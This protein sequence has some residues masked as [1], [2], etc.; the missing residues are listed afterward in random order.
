MRGSRSYLKLDVDA[1]EAVSGSAPIRSFL[2]APMLLPRVCPT[3][4]LDLDSAK[5]FLIG[6][7]PF[8]ATPFGA[9]TYQSR[10]VWVA[11]PGLFQFR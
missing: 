4:V 10:R 11:D 8:L 5:S 6:R 1:R 2:G 3:P 7:F 9:S